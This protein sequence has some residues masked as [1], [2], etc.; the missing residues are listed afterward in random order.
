LFGDLDILSFVI[1]TW[2]NWI[3]NVH[4]MDSKTK[5]STV[6]NNNPQGSRLRGRPK[7]RWWN[8]VHT[9]I[10]TRNITN[11][12]E[13]SKTELN[14]RRPLRKRRSALDCSDIEE[15]RRR[16]WRRRRKR[17]RKGG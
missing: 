4:R 7:I 9:D 1:T 10:N 6:F 5:A 16:R 17:R 12:K 11:W 3:G 13:M 15:R 14:G 2:L 8:C